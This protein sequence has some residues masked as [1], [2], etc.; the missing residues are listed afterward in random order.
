MT[1]AKDWL[2]K[3]NLLKLKK[4][5]TQSS[6]THNQGSKQ[7]VYKKIMATWYEVRQKDYSCDKE[8]QKP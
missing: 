2:Q 7:L 6:R 3:E 8:E 1:G 5:K 4:V